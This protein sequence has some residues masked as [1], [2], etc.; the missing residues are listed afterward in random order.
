MKNILATTQ[1][2]KSKI[3]TSLLSGPDPVKGLRDLFEDELKEMLWN[4]KVLVKAFSKMIKD[5]RSPELINTISDHLDL[6]IKH[7]L[8]LEKVYELIGCRYVVKKCE[9]INILVRKMEEIINQT[10]AGV[11]RDAGIVASAQKIACYEAAAYEILCSF[12]EALGENEAAKLLT[13]TLKEEKETEETLIS[14]A[15]TSMDPAIT[16]EYME[17]MDYVYGKRKTA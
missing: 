4:E 7:I 11:V 2:Q 3:A 9:A 6:T 8:R 10:Q 1:L 17:Y 16:Y 12:A 5:A 15:R 13:Q 14:I